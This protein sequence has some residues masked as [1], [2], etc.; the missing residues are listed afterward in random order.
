[1]PL[2][3]YGPSAQWVYSPGV[4]PGKTARASGFFRQPHRLR[5]GHTLSQQRATHGKA[6]RMVQPQR[7]DGGATHRSQSDEPFSV[8][9]KVDLALITA[10]MEQPDN[11]AGVWI[12]PRDVRTFE[13]VDSENRRRQDCRRSPRRRAIGQ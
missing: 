7:A 4:S 2:L 8:R 10:G 12:D 5:E 3:S 13:I 9:T 11:L 6:K 1:M